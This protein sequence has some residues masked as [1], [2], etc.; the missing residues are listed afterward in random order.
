MP[1]AVSY[2]L[3]QPLSLKIATVLSL[4][5]G[6]MAEQAL[7]EFLE[8]P[9]SEMD[10]ALDELEGRGILLRSAPSY[11]MLTGKAAAFFSAPFLSPKDEG[12]V[13]SASPSEEVCC[14]WA[15]LTAWQA[16]HYK[17]A[18]ELVGKCYKEFIRYNRILAFSVLF[19]VFSRICLQW[20][21]DAQDR[22]LCESYLSTSLRLQLEAQH[23]PR[24]HKSALR[25]FENLRKIAKRINN[26]NYI[27]LINCSAEYALEHQYPDSHMTMH[28]KNAMSKNVFQLPREVN[29]I[30]D[31]SLRNYYLPYMCLSYY[32]KGEFLKSMNCCYNSLILEKSNLENFNRQLYVYASS[33]AIF[34]GEIEVALN[35]LRLAI[36]T[37][38]ELHRSL[39][40]GILHANMGYVYLLKKMIHEFHASLAEA[41]KDINPFEITYAEIFS[42]TLMAFYQSQNGQYV[43]AYHNYKVWLTTAKKKGYRPRFFMTMPF[44]LELMF[45]W[46]KRGLDA[47]H[48]RPFPEELASALRSSALPIRGLALRLSGELLAYEK[49]WKKPEVTSLLEQSLAL[50]SRASVPIEL[51]KV[52]FRLSKAYA[53]SGKKEQS[54]LAADAARDIHRR[55]DLPEL[56]EEFAG[57]ISCGEYGSPIR[58]LPA[59]RAGKTPGSPFLN[60]PQENQEQSASPIIYHS[61]IMQELMTKVEVL[62][63]TNATV[64]VLGESGVGKEGIARKLHALSGKAGRFIPVNLASIPPTLFESEFFGH[65]KGSFTGANYC[66]SG[67]F[68]L[69]HQGTLFLDE[70]ADIPMHIQVKLL[71]ALQEKTFTRVGGTT[72]LSSDF[73]LVAATNK[74]LVQ[75]VKEGRFREDL[76]YRLNVVTLDIPPLRERKDDIF[77]LAGYFL[78]YYAGL[79]HRPIPELTEDERTFFTSYSWPGNVRELKNYIE[80][81]CLL[82]DFGHHPLVSQIFSQESPEH[83]VS[84]TMEKKLP[85]QTAGSGGFAELVA[86]LRTHP[87]MEQMQLAYFE[88]MYIQANGVIAGPDGVAARLGISRGTAHKM[89]DKLNLRQRFSKRLVSNQS[90]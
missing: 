38:R 83:V 68:E 15:M 47:P 79:Y 60:Q 57:I 63:P 19:D 84:G 48:G 21:P 55:Y 52:Q 74:D 43:E 90:G 3:E 45:E 11:C 6:P 77:Y 49:G 1:P 66:K 78:E 85:R 39:D 24:E 72:A 4:G 44:F 89:V 20:E 65:E 88:Y 18:L 10:A 34:L 7:A 86:T 76:F 40:M 22:E 13:L 80:R 75:E 54:R 81:F 53:E 51:A 14:S 58:P 9:L 5:S 71:R 30:T 64:L 73:R 46:H 82:Q 36:K 69:A 16:G 35:I 17:D 56:T 32:T 12:R 29:D 8:T 67:F 23:F 59:P 28:D 62:A 50:F 2:A 27:T 70:V 61:D 87:D 26:S 33:S 41:R 25:W 37:A 31:V 42:T